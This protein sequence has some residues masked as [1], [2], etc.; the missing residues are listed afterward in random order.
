MHDMSMRDMSTPHAPIPGKEM[1]LRLYVF[2]NKL[3]DC[4]ASSRK[5]VIDETVCCIKKSAFARLF[6]C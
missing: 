6:G 2:G 5:Y 1:F 3:S 4:R